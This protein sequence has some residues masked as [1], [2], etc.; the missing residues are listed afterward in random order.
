MS[1]FAIPF[2]GVS[3]SSTTW[4]EFQ[5]LFL[6]SMHTSA[7]DDGLV[8][9][10]LNDGFKVTQRGIGAN[11]SVDVSPGQ[12]WANG[13]AAWINTTTNLPIAAAHATYTRYDYVVIRADN[14]SKTATLTVLQGTPAASPAEPVL[15]KSGSPYY[16]IPLARIT[17]SAGVTS[18]VAAAID[19]RREF[20]NSAPG[21]TRLVKNV[22]GQTMYP[23]QIVVWNDFSPVEVIFTT[24]PADP[25]T[26]GVIASIIPN[27][28]FGLLTVHGIGLVR[29]GEALGTGSRVGTSSTA[30][31]AKE[32]ALNYI[33][34][35]LES[36]PV[37][38]AAGRCWE[39]LS[40]LKHPTITLTNSNSETTTLT[41]FAYVNGLSTAFTMRRP[42]KVMI[43]FSGY[44]GSST[45]GVPVR[46][47]AAIDGQTVELLNYDLGLAAYRNRMNFVHIFDSIH[48]GSHSAGIKWCIG[49]GGSTGYLNGTTLPTRCQI[50][51]L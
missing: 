27:N 2:D 12:G 9:A 3:I 15:D 44:P 48:A 23:G 24:T 39:D 31:L 49:A 50:E 6:S 4:R 22:S 13:L 30:G 38:G 5:R 1:L 36:P 37:V 41:S 7:P 20:V 16:D 32:N 40:Q 11:M 17:V 19:D 51:V 28:S 10:P 14:I 26:A 25:N 29:I 21:V 43:T 35:L 34:T 8:Y 18:I 33:A 47:A 42:G 46:I 45:A